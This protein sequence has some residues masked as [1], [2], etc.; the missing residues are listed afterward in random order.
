MSVSAPYC[1][2]RN[3]ENTRL[4]ACKFRFSQLRTPC[5]AQIQTFS[6]NKEEVIR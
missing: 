3:F 2:A 4:L 6:I 5:F 1:V